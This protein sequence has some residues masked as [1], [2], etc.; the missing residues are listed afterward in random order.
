MQ[1]FDDSLKVLLNSEIALPPFRRLEFLSDSTVIVRFTDG[2]MTFDTIMPY[3]IYQGKT[4]ISLGPSPEGTV[5][6]Y[7]G[8][9]ANSLVL[10]VLSTIYSYKKNNGTTDYD[11]L[12]IQYS[13]ELNVYTIINE[14]R[15]NNNLMPNDTIA[16]NKAGYVFK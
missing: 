1:G 8:V 10:G 9:E 11:P 4:K 3:Q 2:S 15:N 12:Y 13:E 6:F 14:L 7:N 5:V 16:V